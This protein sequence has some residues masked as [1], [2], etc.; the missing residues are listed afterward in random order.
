M[1][2]SIPDFVAHRARD[3]PEMWEF[4]VENGKNTAYKVS[5]HGRVENVETSTFMTIGRDGANADRYNKVVMKVDGKVVTRRICN[6]VLG[7]FVGPPGEEEIALHINS[8]L[9]DTNLCNLRWGPRPIKEKPIPVKKPLFDPDTVIRHRDRDADEIWKPVIHNDNPTN[10]EVSSY[11]QV[12]NSVRGKLRS[13]SVDQNGYNKVNMRVGGKDVTGRICRLV[14][15]AFVGSPAARETAD[16]INRVRSDDNLFNLRWATPEEQNENR[17]LNSTRPN[18]YFGVKAVDVNDDTNENFFV[19]MEEAYAFI[20]TAKSGTL[21]KAIASEKAFKGFLWSYNPIITPE[22]GAIIKPIPGFAGYLASADGLI[23]ITRGNTWR[24]GNIKSG[25]FRV[26]VGG[27]NVRVHK[28]IARAFIG[29]YPSTDHVINHKDGNK[30][31]NRLENLE[32]ISRSENG[33]HAFA[34]NLSI[35]TRKRVHQYALDGTLV[36]THDSLT[37]AA[38]ELQCDQGAISRCCAKK[39]KKH[40]GFAWEFASD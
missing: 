9:A 17:S 25:Y 27:E 7:I 23:R 28:L 21:A 19:S 20:G 36:K 15:I 34:E 29:E 37:G 31:N 18:A 39:R 3:D 6:L 14:L 11:G 35:P 26:C 22:P 38:E 12:R 24:K 30:L 10:Y 8:D 5:T 33:R 4:I 1:S 16:H 40:A 32:Y 2:E 13:I